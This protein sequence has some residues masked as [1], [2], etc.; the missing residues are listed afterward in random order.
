MLLHTWGWIHYATIV[1]ISLCCYRRRRR[2]P[3]QKRIN[4]SLH[5]LIQ[6]PLF[7]DNQAYFL[8]MLCLTTFYI[9]HIAL[10]TFYY[11]FQASITQTDI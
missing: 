3:F 1:N 4:H 2:R 6:P 10:T 11:L 5:L 8:S 7:F 9:V